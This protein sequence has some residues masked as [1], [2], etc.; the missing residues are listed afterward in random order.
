MRYH[1]WKQCDLSILRPSMIGLVHQMSRATS[2]R[3][4]MLR[5]RLAFVCYAFHEPTL[6]SARLHRP[7][8]LV[9]VS[10]AQPCVPC[11]RQ[12][13]P[14]LPAVSAGVVVGGGLCGTLC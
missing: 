14:S 6:Q 10:V 9:L 5:R 7:V 2:L 4:V 3:P 8:L 12:P 11:L 1:V 13:H